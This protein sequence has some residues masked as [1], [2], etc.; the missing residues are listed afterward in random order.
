MKQPDIALQKLALCNKEILC[1]IYQ[2]VNSFQ[3][4]SRL[5]EK[6]EMFDSLPEF[7]WKWYH[8]FRKETKWKYVRPICQAITAIVGEKELL[9]YHHIHN[10]GK[11]DEEFE[12]FWNIWQIE[13]VTGKVLQPLKVPNNISRNNSSNNS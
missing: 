13:R 7:N 6:P 11:T 9:R 1:E 3:W 4:D 10:L 5:G 12:Q 8:I 2:K